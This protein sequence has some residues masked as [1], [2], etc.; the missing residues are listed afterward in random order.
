MPLQLVDLGYDLWMSNS[1]GTKYSK[2][3]TLYPYAENPAFVTQYI[4]QNKAKYDY[5]WFDQGVLDLPA[6]MDKVYEVTQQK[7]TYVGYGEGTSQLL[8]GLTQ[9]EETYFAD[10]LDKAILLA[11]CLYATSLGLESYEETF[12][13]YEQQL[14]NVVNDPNWSYDVESLCRDPNPATAVNENEVACAHAQS[15]P[16]N[17][18][19]MTTKSLELYE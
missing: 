14:I 15:F 2:T 1:R 9:K 12:P 13:V 3:N 19:Q 8:Y 10:K 7:M 6:F 11:P 16:A 5:T 18:E 17:G 4:V